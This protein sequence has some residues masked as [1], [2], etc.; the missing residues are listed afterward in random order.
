[1][2]HLVEQLYAPRI[3]GARSRFMDTAAAAIFSPDMTPDE[4]TLFL[5]QFSSLGVKMTEPVEGWIRR[6]GEKCLEAGLQRLG[7]ALVI[8]ATHEANHH[9]MMIEDTKRLVAHY[10]HAHPRRLDAGHYLAAAPPPSVEAYARLHEDVIAS[11]APFAQLAIEYEIEGLSVSLG[12]KFVQHCVKVGGKDILAG[13]SFI[14]EHAAIDVGHTLF[15][16]LE[17]ERILSEDA[18]RV[19]PLARAGAAALDAYAGFLIDSMARAKADLE[20][21]QQSAPADAV[22]G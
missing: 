22:A 9:L 16:E 21:L 1:M 14:E 7:R 4:L 15:N 19:E 17:L 5:I 10:N 20:R 2:K 6:A 3:A 12:P 11:D 13:L 18:G 8:H